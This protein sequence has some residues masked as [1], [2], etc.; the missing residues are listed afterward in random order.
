MTA[1]TGPGPLGRLWSTDL[2]LEE[3]PS[4]R[5]VSEHKLKVQEKWKTLEA[6]ITGL[7]PVK[8]KN[9]WIVAFPWFHLLLLVLCFRPSFSQGHFPQMENIA[10]FKPVSTSPVHST[11]GFPERSSYCQSAASQAELQACHQAFCVQDC[12]YRSSTP[13]YAPLLLP[14]HR[15]SCVTEDYRDTPKSETGSTLSLDEGAPSVIFWPDK[16]G[17]FV[18]PPSQKLGPSGSLTL[19]VWIKPN[20]TGE[21]MILEMSS[22]ESLAFAVTVSEHAVTLRYGQSRGHAFQTI[23]FR[24]SGRL[25]LLTWTHLVLQ[26]HDTKVSLFLDGLEEDGTPF[27]TQTLSN[28]IPDTSEGDAMWV[29][30]SSNGSNQ[31]IGHMQDFRF[32]PA[33]LTNR[34]IVELYSGILPKVHVQSECRCPPTH[35]RIHPLVERYC[36]PN[37][38]EDTTNDRTPRLN[39]NTHPLSY[40]NDQDMGTMWLSRVMSTQE[41]DEGLTVSVDL[42][43]GQ[44]QVFYVIIQFGSLLPE[45]IVFQRR[46]VDVENP[47]STEEPWSDWQYM[48]RNCSLFEMDNNGPLLRPDSVNCL[49]LPSE[50]PY[51]DGNITFSL[52]TSEPNLRPGYN[53]FYNT[54]ALQKMVYATQVRVHLS[55]QYLTTETGVNH[56]HRYYT[57]K[58]ITISGRCE[59]HG[60]ADNCD[61]SVSPYRCSCLSESHTEGDNCQRCA[62]LFNDKPFKSG[63]QLQPMNC[64]PC[65]CYSHAFSCHYEAEADNHPDEHYRGGG[66][67]CDHCMHN[68]S[69]RNCEMCVSLFFR[70]EGS[71]PSLVDVCQPC[72]CHTAGTV[73]GS[74]ICTQVGG[75]CYCKPAVT[76]RRCT[77]CL[78][79]WYGLNTSNPNGCFQCNCSE[80]GTM[81]PSAEGG[82][83]CDQHTGQCPCKPHVTGLSCDRCEFGFWNLSHANGCVPCDCDPS[84]SLSV[85]CEPE[86]GQCECR[87]GVGG[88]RCASCAPGS[89]GL[90]ESCSPCNCSENGTVAGTVCDPHTGQCVCKENVFGRGCDTCKPGYHT[91][92]HRNSFG[93]LPCVCDLSGTLPGATC[94]VHTGQCPCR[95]GVEGAQCNSCANNYYNLSASTTSGW[96]PSCVPCSCDP[97]GTM[98]GSVC[99]SSTGQC[100]CLSTRHGRDCSSCRPGFYLSPNSSLCVRCDCHPSGAEQST[101][102]SHT[103]QCLCAHSSVGGR[104][105]EHCLDMYFGFDPGTGRC[106]PCACDPVGSLNGSCHPESGVCVCKLLVTGDRCDVCQPG[107]HYLVAENPYGCSKAPSQQPPPIATSLN[108]SAVWLTW[109]PPDSPYSNKLNYTLIRDGQLRHTIQ[110]HYPFSNES[111]EDT[112]L[113]PYT[114]YTYWL[115]TAN[116]AGSTISAS[117]SCQTLG[118]P[119][120]ADELKLK[121]VGRPGPTS[122]YFAWSAPSNDTGPVEKFLLFSIEPN[123]EHF[124]HYTGLSTEAVASDLM[125]FTQYSAYLEACSSGGCTVSKPLSLLTA[126]APPQNQPPPNVTT[127]GP[128]TLNASWEP[129]AQPNGVI[130]KYEVFLRGPFESY[131][132]SRQ[133][134]EE[135]VFTSSGWL[136]LSM[137]HITE[138]N[139]STIPP[140]ESSSMVTGLQAFSTYQ[141]RVV[142]S[143]MAGSVTSQ[144]TTAR[145]MEGVPEFIAP[146]QV[147]AL[148]AST[149]RVTWNATEGHGVIARGHVT[150]YHVNLVTEQSNSPHAPRVINQVIYRTNSS[151]EPVYIVEGLKPYQEYMFSVT[152]CTKAACIT[153]SPSTGRTLSAAPAGL[154]P[155]QLYPV[156]EHTIQILWDPPAQ[157]NGPPPLYQLERIDVSLSDP[158]TPVVRGTRFPGNSFYEFPDDT[159]PTNTD[160]TGIRLSFRTQS[161]DGLLIAAFSPGI[162]EEFIAIQLKNGQLYFI[163]DPQ[164]SPVSVAANNGE[165]LHDDQWHS[166]T[167]TR[168]GSTG[169]VTIDDQYRGTASA[170]S[171]SSIIGENTG[172]FIGGLPE[173]FT[174]QRR[175]LGES[176]VELVKQGFTGCLRDVHFLMMDSPFKQWKPLNWTSATRKTSAYESW[177]G[178]PAQLEEGAHFLGHGYLELS[179]N[180]FRGGENFKINFEFRTDQLDALLLFTYNT[181]SDDYMLVQLRGG[182]L[183]FI[184][185]CEG[186]VTSLVMWAGLGYCDGDWKQ[187][188][189]TKEGSLLSAAVD[190]WEDMTRG[191]GQNVLLQ[192]DSP[193]YLGGVPS[194]LSHPA[195][196][197]QSH[198]HGLGGCIRRVLISDE[199]NPDVTPFVNLFVASLGSVRVFLGGCPSSESLYN[200]RGND[201]VLI[202]TGKNTQATDDN[203]QP[204]T[205]YFYRYVALGTGGLSVGPWQRGRSQGRVPQVVPSPRSV[206]DLNGFSASVF[207]TPPTEELMGMIDYYEL[208]AYDLDNPEEAPITATYLA[209]GNFTGVLYGL[210]PATRYSIT[211]SACTHFGCTESPQKH[212]DGGLMSLLTTPEEAPDAVFPPVTVSSPT[213]LHVTWKPP[214]KPNGV[215]IEYLLYHNGQMVYKGTGEQYNIAGLA[216]YSTHVLVVSACTSA[217]CTNSSQVT[218]VTSQLPPGPLQAPVLTRLDSRTILVEWARPSQVNGVLESYS[219]FASTEDGPVLVHNSTDLAEEHTL[220]NLTPGTAY[221]V[222]VAACTGGGCTLSPPSRAKTEE[223]TPEDIPAPVVT[224]IS[225]HAFNVSWTPP[226]TPNGVITSYGLWLDGALVLNSSSSERFFVVDGLSPWSQHVLRLQACTARGCGK[227]PLTEMHTLEMAPEGPILLELTN[228]SSRSVRVRWTAP[229]RPNGNLTYT[230]Y[231]KNKDDDGF[232]DGRTASSSWLTVT[233]LQPYSNYS[234]WIRGCNSRGCVQSL[235][236]SITTPPTAPDGLGPLQLV[237]ATSSS[238]N[239]SWS[240]PERSNGPGPLQYGLQMR[241]S[242]Q[243]S[244]LRL[245]ENATETFSFSVEGLRPYREYVFRG[246]VSHLHGQTLGPWTTFQTAEDKPG[247]VNT[248]T[249]QGLYPRSAELTWAAPLEPNGIIVNYTLYLFSSLDS[250]F[251]AKPFSKVTSLVPSYSSP[252][253]ETYLTW[254]ETPK[255]REQLTSDLNT[256]V[257]PTTTAHMSSSSRIPIQNLTERSSTSQAPGLLSSSSSSSITSIQSANSSV[258]MITVHGNST[259]YTVDGLLPYTIYR[260]QVEA[261]TFVGCTLSEISQSFRTLAAP[262]EGVPAPHVYSNTPTSVLLSWGAEERS[263]GPLERWTVERRV[264]GTNLISTVGHLSPNTPPLSYLDSSSALSPWTTY[265]YRLTLQNVAGRAAGPWANVTTRPSRPAGLSPPRVW[266][267]G[268]ESLQVTWSPPLIPNGE[269][270]R[271]EIRLQDFHIVHDHDNASDYNITVTELTP[272]TNYSVTV[273]ACSSGAGIVG[274]CTESLPTLATTLAAAPQGLAPLTIVPVSES[275]LAISWQPPQRPNGPNIRYKLLRRKTRQPLGPATILAQADTTPSS[276]EDL[277]HWFHVYSGTKLFYQDKGLSR[278]TQYQYQLLVYNDVGNSS[279]DIFTAT[280]M[281]GIP[282]RAPSVSAFPINHTTIY[283]NWTQPS[284]HDLQGDVESYFIEVKSVRSSEM[285]TFSANVTSAV[286]S[287][288]WPSTMYS[289]SLHVSNGAHNTTKAMVNITTEDGEPEGM[290]SPEVVP[291]NSSS[292]RVLWSPPLRSNGAVTVYNIYVNDQQQASGD[293]SSGSYLLMDLLPFT[294]YSVQVEVCT[295]YACVKSDPTYTTTVEDLPVDFTAPNASV[296]SSRAVRLDWSHPGRPSG[297]MLGYEVL[298]R[299]IRSC[300]S[301]SEESEKPVGSGFTC[302]YIQCPA[303]HAVCGASCF[304]PDTEVCCGGLLFPKKPQYHCC[305]DTYQNWNNSA[306]PVC[307]N[308]KLLAALPEHQCCGGYYIH[309]KNNEYCCPDHA[310]GRVS[311]GLGD[312]CC[313]GVPYSVRG[314]Q[315]CC[316]GTLHDGYGLQCCGGRVVDHSLVCCGDH[317]TAEVHTYIQNFV[318]CGREYINS[319][320]SLCCVDNDGFPKIHPA[321][322]ATVTLQCCGS[323][324]IPEDEGCCSGIGYDPQ[325]YVCADRPTPGL[326]MERQ[327]LRGA[328]CP[329]VAA[330]TAYCGSCD[331]DP[332]TSTCTWTLSHTVPDTVMNNTLSHPQFNESL[333]LYKIASDYNNYDVQQFQTGLCPSHEEVVYSGDAKQLS[334]TDSALEPHTTYEYRVRGWNSFGRGSSDAVVVTTLEDKPWGVA[335]PHWSRVNDRDDIIY[336]RWQEPARPNGEI[337]HYVILRDGQERYRGDETSFTDVG[338]IGAFQ[339]YSYQLRACNRAG[340]ADSPQVSAVTVQDVP[341]GVL[342]PVVTALSSTSL[343]VTWTQPSRPNGAIQRYYLNQTSVGTIL[344]H[345]DGAQNYTVMGLQPYTEYTFVLVAC[346][347]VG[348]GA[349]SPSTGR[350]LQAVPDGVWWRPRHL[351][352]N[353]SAVELYWDQP[354]RPNGL[355]SQ[356]TLNRD[357]NTIFTGGQRDQNF[358]DTGLLPNHSYVYELEATTEGGASRSDKYVIQTPITSP[359]GIPAPHNVT[360]SSPHS[361]S[362][363]WTPLAHFNS[364]QAVNYTI[365]LN[366]DNSKVS[367]FRAGMDLQ[368]NITDLEPFTT[369]FIRVQACQ[370][371]GCGVGNGAYVQTLEAAPEDMMPPTVLAVGPRVLEVHWLPPNKPNGPITSYHIYRRPHQTTQDLLVFIWTS[372]PL[373][374]VDASPSLRPFSYYQYRVQA[375]NSKGSALSHWA[376]AQTLQAQPQNMAAP[377]VTATGA[378]SVHLKWSEP[379]QPNGLISHY[380]LVYKKH[381]QDPTLN[382]TA[383][384][385]LTVEGSTWEATIFGFAPYSDYTFQVEAINEAGSIFSPW[386]Q[387]KTLEASPADLTN[388]TVEHREQGRALLLSWGEPASPNGVITMYNLYSEGLLE[389]S[390]QSRSFLFRRLEP[391][392]VY[393][394]TLEACTSAGCTRTFSQQVTTAA[395]PPASQPPPTPL[396]IGTDQVSLTWGPPSEPNGP[397]G[398]YILLGRSPDEFGR[399]RSNDEDTESGKVLFRES[400]PH[401]GETFS[402][403][404]T[405]LRPWTQYEFSIQTYNPAGHTQSPWA[406]VMTRQAPPRGLAPPTVSHVPGRPTELR[407]FWTAPMEP[408]GVLQSYRIIRN[409]ISFAFSFDPTVLSYSDEDLS[410]FSKYSYAVTACTSEGC[411]TSPYTNITTL[412]APPAAVEVPIMNNITSSSIRVVWSEP[413]TQNGEVTEYVLRLN[414]EEVYRGSHLHTDLSDLQPHMFYQLSL[415]ACT[416]G[417]CST[418]AVVSARTDEAPPTGLASPSLKVTGSDSVEISWSAPE[419]PNGIVTGYELRRDG[420]VVYVGTEMHYHDFTLLPNVEYSYVITANNSKGQVSSAAATTKT[421]QSAPSGV[422]PPTLTPIGP[423]Q[424]RVEWSAPAR[425]NGEIVRY[426]V[427]K[428]DPVELTVLSSE[429][430][431]EDTAFSDQHLILVGLF[432]NQRYEVRVE[433]CT[434]LGCSSSEWSPVVT[435]E[436]P[437]TG[438]ASPMLD[439]QPDEDTGFETTF[440][441][442]W[443]PPTQP[444]GVI[445]HYEVYRRLDQTRRSN[446]ATLIYRNTSTVY[447]DKGL[448]PYTKYQF[449]VWAVNSAGHAASP[450]TNGRTG[451]GPPEGL[452]RPIFINVLATSAIVKILAPTKPNGIISLYR[453]FSQNHHNYTLLSEGT[454]QQQTLHGLHPYTRYW[455]GVE[456]CT[457]FQC[458]SQGP[459][460]ELRTLSAPPAQQP[461]PRPISLT[462]RSVQLQW[463]QPLAPNG[464]IENCE[465]HLRQ[466]CPQPPQP[467]PVPCVEGHIE[468]CYSGTS[469]SHNVTGLKPYYSYE[470]RAACFNNMGSTASNWTTVTTLSEAP[471][472]VAPFLVGSNL[473]TVWLEWSESFSL[474]GRLKEYTVTERKLRVYSGFYSSLHIPLTSQKS[475]SLQVTCTTDNGSASTPVIKYSPTFGLDPGESIDNGKQG[476]SMSRTPVYSEL[477]FILLFSILGLFLLALLIGLVLQ[478]ALRKDPAARERPPLVMLQKTSKARG[479]VYMFDTVADSIEVSNVVLKS[480]TVYSEALSDTKISTMPVLRVPSQTDLVQAY[481]QHSLHRS[482]SQLIDRKSLM[483]EEGSWDNPLGQ[484]SGLYVEEEEFGDAV[485]TLS[486][487]KK[488]HTMFTDTHL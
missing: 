160:F 61:T 43:N 294:V 106:Q 363:G 167:A 196:D 171:G 176:N 443:S 60:H 28:K 152:L 250:E 140:P 230:L 411:V 273:L 303:A 180:V 112:D 450:W 479:E 75:Q 207:W 96:S 352:I 214:A 279:G 365:I 358:T 213:S 475:L 123:G 224:P 434:A 296:I 143:N 128:H 345:T 438:Q 233:D 148:S 381:Q 175:D 150:E 316:D 197:S 310:Q 198:K 318:C 217:G 284:V 482:V 388:F 444:H 278:F 228:H 9:N 424:L 212:T 189:V 373:E 158:H 8:A 357:G 256:V 170:A 295:V 240:A 440:V 272:F 392:T 447:K 14:A 427:H 153:S 293:N 376:L 414:D 86:G 449:Q 231:Y 195:L 421:H 31:F 321:G 398:E 270:H 401:E 84:G 351:I 67:V 69:G 11:C 338:G 169:T 165:L 252:A 95:E 94:D 291:V 361:I 12:L 281:A 70:R 288:L 155:P 101:C 238:L 332:S 313:G 335:P 25:G 30:L 311:V 33:T 237:S 82:L 77:D 132:L 268:P 221:D 108:Y 62:P 218:V 418:S 308:G 234:F 374:F 115:V 349:S 92:D 76:G 394:L 56:G 97:S 334:F 187:F 422:A 478:R 68:T 387:I 263:N 473:T 35:P 275:F 204:F 205:E 4:S 456:A 425:P 267:L 1:T 131:N 129:P 107:S 239:L 350:T 320:T 287:D 283:I 402:Y 249:V 59:C 85:F 13:P 277:H 64:R 243:T 314:G 403:T 355:I 264:A 192:V 372:G 247:P 126:S 354:A 149:F 103:G 266:V 340:C 32:Y 269:I 420:E 146:P 400:S 65:Q 3:P 454:S 339:E 24:T 390:G 88:R 2:L 89:F 57:V 343:T 10:A 74:E 66:G 476:V 40:L 301:G 471:Q 271:Y 259:S 18:S 470:L 389:F 102:E 15:G 307:C 144:W 49:T 276:T 368:A 246:T 342:P 326:I 168:K 412:E 16:D 19:A 119:P 151:S 130:T 253:T 255:T 210:T 91:L 27:E 99:D 251:D 305:E 488:E 46:Y 336:L 17:C 179:G 485:K 116:V 161:P 463:D 367:M 329:I 393:N 87:P 225:P 219:I 375:L 416:R 413:R 215:I 39:E 45:N 429:F 348:C 21:M 431:P 181:Q 292:V 188:S 241:T 113:S 369:Y 395:A 468:V 285:Y 245:L 467:V 55:G 52:L 324:V 122:A 280:T 455:V 257:S 362:L 462:S 194:A 331:L 451:P 417:G 120:S 200:C 235:P 409:N 437:P 299:T 315:L 347:A 356:Y 58:E 183:S 377:T 380:R 223:S 382:S 220:R 371:D 78:P 7:G 93:C 154:S 157:L 211:V 125:P 405:G 236:F 226:R 483:L 254:S 385:A 162:Q 325:R 317:K 465:L 428:R 386:V 121:I 391:W 29:G 109:R 51:S 193:F 145:T 6:A 469:W 53:D 134:A 290:S 426:I 163:F 477:W 286:I 137:S 481:S 484:D 20:T 436:A 41:L 138:T 453:V 383:V 100:V 309:V 209:N 378:Y 34:E 466:C 136:D 423:D 446:G 304:H 127:T 461:A 191:E 63:N 415:E 260:L 232:V 242:L 173:D 22:E 399:G 206:Q 306:S 472:Y 261:C 452:H 258:I 441:L 274:G 141:I 322:N 344:T 178:C 135:L 83:S 139:S 480:Y 174:F 319:S 105:C 457:C 359:T 98:D 177:E 73:N 328:I 407:V 26:I 330:S 185:S 265:Q 474:N 72:N 370:D 364:D 147:T 433:A 410:P 341:E 262:A 487:V 229:P 203:L 156:N 182:F 333:D 435:L 159:L 460:K 81:S 201:S 37:A 186:E 36:I 397:I 118:A 430:T 164:G 327:C 300:G 298:R 133:T 216:V 297:I 222:T 486:S 42:L 110:S 23:S 432:P 464:V 79:G 360:V 199:R 289:V 208:K 47:N 202:Y 184:V 404:V 406:T 48:A 353:T 337:T 282:L 244:V 248:P 114:N 384:T 54:P 442:T 445:L 190:D 44:Y 419:Q 366:S 50:V 448:Q 104:R 124:L 90:E 166:I 80:I 38:V 142:S 323:K 111:F 458:C 172:V 379:E 117:V 227:G 5:D 71:D 346:T 408:N 312:S 302:T 459:V 439:L 396:F